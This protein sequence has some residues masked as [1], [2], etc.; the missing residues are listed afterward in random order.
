MRLRPTCGHAPRP[1]RLTRRMRP[2]VLVS[3]GL[4]PLLAIAGCNPLNGFSSGSSGQTITV[5]AVPSIENANLYLAVHH[6]YFSRAGVTVKIERFASVAKEIAAL[7]SGSVD[8]I[9]A[10]YGDMLYE[11]ASAPHPIY[12]IL[13]DGYDAGPGVVEIV[14]MPDSRVKSPDDL[15]GLHIPVP[16]N[17]NVFGLPQGVPNTLALAAATSVL[18]SD[19]VN[20]AGVIWD[21]MSQA[22]EINELVSGQAPAILVTGINVLTAEQDGAIELIDG[23]SGPTSNIPL[24]GFFTTRAWVSENQSAAKA[25]QQGLYQADASTV[26][27]GPIQSVLHA[28]VGL[29]YSQADLVSTGTYPL[30]T[31]AADIQRTADLMA[32]EG[33]T[34]NEVNVTAMIV[35]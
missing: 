25:F 35:R 3:I 32:T 14:T 29:T 8:V 2:I 33:M 20:L 28:Y 31:I 24:D 6:G 22:Q 13:T 30:S 4:L 15:A 21:P 17:E 27:P 19:G 23:C 34:S 18:Q 16:N 5:A 11:Q 10:D 26:M 12:R 1:G 7:N 9:A